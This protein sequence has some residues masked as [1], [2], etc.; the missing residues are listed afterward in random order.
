MFE[1]G[2]GGFEPVTNEIAAVGADQP[3]EFPA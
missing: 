2:A 3:A 1:G